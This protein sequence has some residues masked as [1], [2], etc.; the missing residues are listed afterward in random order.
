MMHLTRRDFAKTGL[1]GLL[2]SALAL[3]PGKAKGKPKPL[4]SVPKP[5]PERHQP[6]DGEV[7]A[8]PCAGRPPDRAGPLP[9][10]KF[11]FLPSKSAVWLGRCADA[12]L[13]VVAYWDG[14]SDFYIWTPDSGMR[15]ET[16]CDGRWR[17]HPTM[18]A[19]EALRRAQTRGLLRQEAL[20]KPK[21]ICVWKSRFLGPTSLEQYPRLA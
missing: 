18:S 9:E 10:V 13:W 11:N 20:L 17:A 3:W 19:G 16:Y 6:C 8:V 4:P 1:G 7:V 21:R 15:R 14:T 2:A 12:E 5:Q